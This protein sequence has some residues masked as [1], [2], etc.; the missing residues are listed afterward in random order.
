[1]SDAAAAPTSCASAC[2]LP[3]GANVYGFGE[4]F[5]AAREERPG[6]RHLE[7]GRRHGQRAG[8]QDAAVLPHRRGLRRVRRLTG[9]G[10]VRG[11]RRRSSP[12]C[13]SPCPASGWTTCV[14]YGPTP[15]EILRKYTALTGRPALPPRWSFGLWLSTSF[16]TDYDEPTVTELRRRHGR[17]RDPAERLPLRLLLDEAAQLVR[18]R[19]GPRRVPRARA[20]ARAPGRARP[21][22]QRVDQPVHRAALAAV[23][24]RPRGARAISLRRPGRQRLAV[25]HVGSRAWRWSTSPTRPRATGSRASSGGAARPGV[26]A[27]RP[28][29]ASGSRRT[30]C[31]PT[32]PTRSGCTTTTRYLYN[33]TV[34]EVL[35]AHRGAG[36]AVLFAR[37]AT[38]GGQRFPVHWGGDCESTYV[39]MAES[40]RGGLS[41]GLRR[42]RLLEPRHRRLRGHAAAGAVQAL[43]RVRAD[44]LALPPARLELAPRALGCSTRRP[45]TSLRQ[46]ARLKN[47]PHAVPV[48]GRR[49]GARGGDADDAGDGAGVP[50]RPD[51]RVS[52]PAVHARARTCWSRPCSP[53]RAT[54][55]STCPRAVDALP[56]G[57]DA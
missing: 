16:L 28:T 38:V 6:R 18:L 32:G 44:V 3:V 51:V 25:G 2:D 40:L 17:A 33:R 21:A 47:S 15:A 27:S 11:R 57:T 22:P 34:F 7:R 24:A 53:T 52:G 46:F 1:M 56:R 31:G 39:S 29:S 50:G 37:S 54:S 4:R 36:E 45:S 43:G 30:W 13:S 26:D 9:A 8:L 35:E 10:V 14:I 41:L 19:V 5:S 12:R 49:A 23:R 20:D 48:R 55:T 42:V